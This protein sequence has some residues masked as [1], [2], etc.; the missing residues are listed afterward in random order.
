M[1][2][3]PHR[4]VHPMSKPLRPAL[5]SVAAVLATATLGALCH[6]APAGAANPLYPEPSKRDSVAARVGDRVLSLRYVSAEWERSEPAHRPSHADP[7]QARVM[8]L[9]DLVVRHALA[10]EARRDP[11]PLPPASQARLDGEQES[12]MLNRLFARVILEP[13]QVDTVDMELFVKELTNMLELRA[14]VF[15]TEEAARAW[16]SRLLA[17]TPISRLEEA[18]RRADPEILQLIEYSFVTREDMNDSL[19]RVVF[20]IPPGRSSPPTPMDTRWSLYSVASVRQ[21]PP[22]VNLNDTEAVLK[23]VRDFRIEEV[24]EAYRRGLTDSLG[25]VYEWAAMDTLVTRFQA[26]PSR[27]STDA[28]GVPTFNVFLP[29]P[30]LQPGDSALV[31]ARRGDHA[32]DTRQVMQRLIDLGAVNR[33]EIKTREDLRAVV[34][35]VAVDETLRKRA[36]AMGLDKD[37]LVVEIVERRREGYLV[38]R[39]FADSVSAR[40]PT[41]LDTLE[42]YFEAHRDHFHQAATAQI[43]MLVTPGRAEGDSLLGVARGGADLAELARAHS[44]HSESGLKGGGPLPVRQGDNPNVDVDEAIFATPAGE[45]GGP[46]Q[47]QD[48][49]VIFRVEEKSEGRAKTFEEELSHVREDFR[50]VREEQLLGGFLERAMGRVRIEKFPERVAALAK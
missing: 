1:P 16:Y 2:F 3:A 6:T 46:V 15:P 18:A 38:E 10:I 40:V 44:I 22:G 9:D 14:F 25:V 13:T 5:A 30:V 42:A 39:L 20:R 8:F 24:R 26:V 27:S 4:F 37:P 50:R 48:G 43:W 35:R 41:D 12:A 23:K 21:R 31:L 34:D 36:W 28:F 29:L 45:F 19:A 32:V 33:P 7:R 47:T 11:R 49:W 17:G